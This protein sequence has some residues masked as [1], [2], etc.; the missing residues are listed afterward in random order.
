MKPRSR[1]ILAPLGRNLSFANSNLMLSET[2][3]Y[4]KTDSGLVQ[5][6]LEKAAD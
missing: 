2:I 1:L 6:A 5:K 3:G 4:P